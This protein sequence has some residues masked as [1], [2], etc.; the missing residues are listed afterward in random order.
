MV[1]L[2]R[3]PKLPAFFAAM[4]LIG[5]TGSPY[6]QV[7]DT[8]DYGP[9]STKSNPRLYVNF[10][11]S[12][13]SGMGFNTRGEFD[14]SNSLKYFSVKL[15]SM[16]GPEPVP[17]CYELTTSAAT[18]GAPNTRVWLTSVNGSNNRKTQSISSGATNF[19]RIFADWDVTVN[20]AFL[21]IAASSTANN[22]KD[23]YVAI[24]QVNFAGWWPAEEG[25]ACRVWG[26]PFINYYR[27]DAEGF[28]Y[29]ADTN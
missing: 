21:N 7:S 4:L 24:T 19:V 25:D 12:A 6:A 27:Q 11:W 14:P 28:V 17:I 16:Q 8:Y 29:T 5:G 20:T 26:K 13:A 3:I 9:G 23:F 22:S 2:P 15:P 18:T 10:A 1:F